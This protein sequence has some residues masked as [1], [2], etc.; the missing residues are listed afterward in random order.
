MQIFLILLS[1][2]FSPSKLKLKNLVDFVSITHSNSLSSVLLVLSPF[3]I[4]GTPPLSGFFGKLAIP[5]ALIANDQL[6][7]ALIAVPFSVPTRIYY[8]RIIRSI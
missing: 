3:P 8:T 1:I 2:R 6:F 4:A 5:T 7:L